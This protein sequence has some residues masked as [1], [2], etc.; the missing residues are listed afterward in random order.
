MANSKKSAKNAAIKRAMALAAATEV[1]PVPDFKQTSQIQRGR[2]QKK[3]ATTLEEEPQSINA[4]NCEIWMAS[5]QLEGLRKGEHGVDPASLDDDMSEADAVQLRGFSKEL[6]ATELGTSLLFNNMKARKGEAGAVSVSQLMNGVSTTSG[7]PAIIRMY[8]DSCSELIQ[9]AFGG[10][11]DRLVLIQVGQEL[12][13]LNL[14]ISHL[15][16]QHRNATMTLMMRLLNSQHPKL[17]M[18]L[19]VLAKL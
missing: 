1:E 7:D 14:A 5:R 8:E 16:S 11:F 6:L 2:G 19:M 9:H 10:L 4:Q 12:G 13:L 15:Y 17:I 3:A 18:I